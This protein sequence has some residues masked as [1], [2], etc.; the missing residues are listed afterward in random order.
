MKRFVL[1]LLA[2]LT[3]VSCRTGSDAKYK[4]AHI[5]MEGGVPIHCQVLD[6]G[7]LVH[8]YNTMLEVK[9]VEYGWIAV[10]TKN[11]ILYQTDK[12]PICNR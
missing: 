7:A 12:C 11:F 10:D 3:L 1:F 6:V 5:Y 9:T 2:A 8:S 4:K